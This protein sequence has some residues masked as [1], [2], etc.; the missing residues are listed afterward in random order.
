[1]LR[2][3]GSVNIKGYQSFPTAVDPSSAPSFELDEVHQ[4]LKSAKVS[5]RELLQGESKVVLHWGVM[6][7]VNPQIKGNTDLTRMTNLLLFPAFDTSY[8]LMC[9]IR[10]L[11]H[12]K[13]AAAGMVNYP[14]GLYRPRLTLANTSLRRPSTT[15]NV[16]ALFT[17]PGFDRYRKNPLPLD[18]RMLFHGIPVDM[19]VCSINSVVLEP[20]SSLP[21]I[22]EGLPRYDASIDFS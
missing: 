3:G 20:S 11:V 9:A 4:V 16:K 13:L 12:Q 17:I 6:R 14:N 2:V 15:F 22:D 8:H 19:G 5:I 21:L 7:A 1:M 18:D 10:A